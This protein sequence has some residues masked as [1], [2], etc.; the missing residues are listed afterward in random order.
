MLDFEEWGSDDEAWM[1]RMAEPGIRKFSTNHLM[2]EGY[3]CWLIPLS[4]GSTSI[5]IVADP[6]FHPFEEM[7]TLE[8]ALDWFARNE[9]QVAESLAGRSDDVQDFLKLEHFSLGTERVLSPERWAC[10]GDAGAFLD[11]LISPGSDF[12]A[13]NN[14]LIADTV[15]R[16]LDD[17]DV[18]GRA[19]TLNGFYLNLFNEFLEFYVDHYQLLGNSLVFTAKRSFDNIPGIA[20]QIVTVAGRIANVPFEPALS[21]AF[22]RL[23]AL[24]RRVQAILRAWHRLEPNGRA[25]AFVFPPLRVS[26]FREL[27][28]RVGQMGNEVGEIADLL[29]A[30][31]K[32]GEAAAVVIFHHAAGALPEGGPDL[33]GPSIRTSS[34][35][36]LSSGSRTPCSRATV[37][38][39]NRGGRAS[40]AS[41]RCSRSSP[42][43]EPGIGQR[44]RR[45]CRLAPPG[46]PRAR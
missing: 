46:W 36:I 10:T 11:P 2:G 29:A 33:T 14:S 4:S 18:S 44:R 22:E 28:G 42:S 45:S 5:G 15:L 41:T 6:R 35:S 26:N 43:S 19:E 27:M 24:N 38:R 8:G 21:E 31:V 40:R 3:W 13:I 25:G 7:D 1:S 30:F 37:S 17:A 9:P 34:R 20:L 23:F 16:D 32:L 39:S 12:I